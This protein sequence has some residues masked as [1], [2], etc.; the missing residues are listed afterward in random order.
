MSW[1]LPLTLSAPLRLAFSVLGKA[2]SATAWQGGPV[3]RND[4]R[5]E[6]QGSGASCGHA[7]LAARLR[8]EL[9]GSS[10]HSRLNL[11]P[12]EFIW[13]GC[14]ESDLNPTPHWYRD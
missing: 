11:R 6:I 12:P 13:A 1:T 8:G 2:A 14:A 7:R 3:L 4:V 5:A 9:E 10:E